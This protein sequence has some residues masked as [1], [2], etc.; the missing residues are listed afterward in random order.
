VE[1]PT[2]VESCNDGGSHP[3]RYAVVQVDST[4]CTRG[5]AKTIWQLLQTDPMENNLGSLKS[6]VGIQ[7]AN[8]P[9]PR[10]ATL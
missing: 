5:Y 6:T 4:C 1:A 8:L 7:I 3:C 2:H 9:A 10:D